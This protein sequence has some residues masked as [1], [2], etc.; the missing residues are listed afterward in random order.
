V[1]NLKTGTGIRTQSYNLTAPVPMI[2]TNQIGFLKYINGFYITANGS[3]F[4][5]S[6]DITLINS[7]TYQ[8]IIGTG[9]NTI[10]YNLTLHIIIFDQTAIQAT[11]TDFV[12]YGPV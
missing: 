3:N 9:G 8:V 4:N 12:D 1:T 7:T 11:Y 10:V 6:S 5:V 2:T